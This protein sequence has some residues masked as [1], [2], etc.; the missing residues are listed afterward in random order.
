MT[1]IAKGSRW[2][3]EDRVELAV[4]YTEN[5]ILTALLG[6]LT[7]ISF[8]PGHP[9]WIANNNSGTSTLY[10]GQGNKQPLVVGISSAA[11]NPCNPGCRT[12]T[13]ANGRSDFSG[14]SFIFDTEDG[15][16]SKWTGAP[17]AL[18]AVDNSAGGAASAPLTLDEVIRLI[19]QSKGESRSVAS[20]IAERG[21]DFELEEKVEKKL[22][23]AGAD[24][25]LIAD[26]W[27]VTPSGKAHVRALLTSPSGIDLQASAG[28]AMALQDIQNE[29]APDRRLRMVEAF[30]KK[31]PNSPLL[32]YAYTEAARADQQNGAFDEAVQYGRKSLKLDPDNTFSLIIM[33]SVLPQPKL[34]K[35]SANE[36][37]AQLSEAA[38]DANRALALLEKLRKRPEETD[39]QFEARKGSLAAEAHFALGMEEM[40]QDQFDKAVAEYQAAISSTSKP[41]FQYY[42]RLAEAY[43]SQGKVS[44]A[45]QALQKASEIGRGTPMQKY[46]DDF[47]AELQQRPH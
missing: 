31:F 45:I 46:A 11:V 40:Q 34:L 28:E 29:S 33:A 27:K 15:T 37:A 44:D 32:S 10:D 26:I 7:M 38:A 13:V 36:V 21:V 8:S 6:L 2:R 42:Y 47:I 25:A 43:A 35:G 24:D 14:V 18:V 16:I 1:V 5:F 22:R 4:S 30:E 9:F 19:K 20:A 39:E 12:G 41:T 17:Y 3:N 23:K